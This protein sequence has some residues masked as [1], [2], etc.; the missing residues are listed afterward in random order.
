[1]LT[2]MKAKLRSMIF[3][4]T[5]QREDRLEKEFEALQMGRTSHAEFR[6]LWEEKLNECL[7]A[8]VYRADEATYEAR[9][10]RKYLSKISAELRSTVLGKVWMLDGEDKPSRKP[11]S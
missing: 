6:S 10:K 4:T 2:E 3:E 5:F 1:M 8:G 11:N 7:E 9:L